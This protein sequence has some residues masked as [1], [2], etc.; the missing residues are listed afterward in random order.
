MYELVEYTPKD[1]F[2]LYVVIMLSIVITYPIIRV[3][4]H[5]VGEAFNRWK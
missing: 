1:V 4:I 5:A 2:L 3:M